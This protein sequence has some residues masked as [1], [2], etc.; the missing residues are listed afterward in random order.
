MEAGDIVRI[1]IPPSKE[2]SN[3]MTIDYNS[4]KEMFQNKSGIIIKKV[5]SGHD[6]Y[7]FLYI[8]RLLNDM[9]KE[10]PFYPDEFVLIK[11]VL[12][13]KASPM[14]HIDKWDMLHFSHR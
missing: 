12:I 11:T 6:G 4:A 7:D 1:K 9:D 14:F 13:E 3:W 2:I 10:F 5:L 8:I